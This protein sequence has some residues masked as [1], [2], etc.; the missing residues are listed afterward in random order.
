[1]NKKNGQLKGFVCGVLTTVLVL[2]MTAPALADTVMRDIRVAYGGIS[3]YVD[4]NLQHPTDANGNT[5]EPMIYDGTTYLP[6]R[7]LTNMLTDKAVNWDGNT[8]SVYIGTMPKKANVGLEEINLLSTGKP[9]TNVKT[10][11]NAQFKV[12]D[13]EYSPNNAI[14]FSERYAYSETFV[15]NSEYKELHG[16]FTRYGFSVGSTNKAYLQFYNVD[17]H[18]TETLIA[19]Y[20]SF[21]GNP[22]T[23]VSV[24]LF[25]VNYLEIKIS[26]DNDLSSERNRVF[27]DINLTPVN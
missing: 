7:A 18:G 12:L 9:S 4:G 21:P 13:K 16:H 17:A 24:D 2:G 14:K 1:M 20:E 23:E 19:E 6:V 11:I 22:P 25:G 15:L 8:R 5:V 27:Y 10:G 26:S 3:I